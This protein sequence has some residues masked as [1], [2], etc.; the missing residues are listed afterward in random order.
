[1]A[2]PTLTQCSL[3]DTL[4][5][6]AGSLAALVGADVVGTSATGTA[7]TV[8][9]T[10]RIQA[11]RVGASAT[12]GTEV[13]RQERLVVITVWAPTPALRD[14]I[15]AALDLALAQI[16]FLALPTVTGL[17]SFT[18]TI[19]KQIKR[20]SRQ[21]TAGISIISSNIRPSTSPKPHKFCSPR[22]TSRPPI[23]HQTLQPFTSEAIM[24][25]LTVI[26]PFGDYGRGHRI[27][28]KS[29]ID[30]VLAG[31]NSHHTVKSHVADE[32]TDHE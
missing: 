12:M 1:M 16:E 18:R 20:R 10:G 7:I 17:A 31:E 3:N 5:F 9:P 11:L 26:H 15:G 29:E 21:S 22:P 32:P 14:T 30:E 8:G 6:I 24:L 4:A 19:I 2:S 23:P 13:R 28:E 27:T 25:V